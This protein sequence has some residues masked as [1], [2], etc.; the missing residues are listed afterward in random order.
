MIQLWEGL[1][2]SLAGPFRSEKAQLEAAREFRN[3]DNSETNISLRLDILPDGT[4][5]VDSYSGGA[6]EP[7]GHADAQ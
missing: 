6:M 2:A 3:R 4:P 1:E 7:D 5:E